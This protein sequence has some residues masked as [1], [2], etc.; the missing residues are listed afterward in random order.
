MFFFSLKG[1]SIIEHYFK[2]EFCG[3]KGEEVNYQ[4]LLF[5]RWT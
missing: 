3:Q 5:S 1:L 4:L 2:R